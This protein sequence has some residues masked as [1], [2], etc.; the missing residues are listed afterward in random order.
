L[1]FFLDLSD[2]ESNKNRT[3]FLK[4]SSTGTSLNMLLFQQQEQRCPL[5]SKQLNAI[6][7]S[8]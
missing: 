6:Q 7:N 3:V 8:M 5:H 4:Y 1:P 2:C